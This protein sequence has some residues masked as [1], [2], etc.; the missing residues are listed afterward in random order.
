MGST[1]NAKGKMQKEK[2]K[3]KHDWSV[4]DRGG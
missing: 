2:C 3:R 1:Q 4:G